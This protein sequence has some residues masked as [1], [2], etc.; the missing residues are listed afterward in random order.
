MM[1]TVRV[2]FNVDRLDDG[3]LD[4]GEVLKYL[5]FQFAG[6]AYCVEDPNTGDIVAEVEIGAEPV[7]VEVLS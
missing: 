5:F 2:T 3:S 4:L 1:K 6:G 7:T